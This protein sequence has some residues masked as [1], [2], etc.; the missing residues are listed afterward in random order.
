M[1]H[2]RPRP[3]VE[4]AVLLLR[5]L[6]PPAGRRA[7]R[8]PRLSAAREC[9]RP[10]SG[11]RLTG[12]EAARGYAAPRRIHDREDETFF[13]LDGTVRFVAGDE[14]HSAGPGVLALLPRR[15]PHAFVVTSPNARLLTLITPAGFEGFVVEAGTPPD[16]PVEGPPDV[17]A[18]KA[19]G[20][21]YGVEIIGP[22]PVP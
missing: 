21:R 12:G 16:A 2:P 9:L 15:M 14:E 1:P 10:T 8:G 18:L 11:P 19:M 17:E 4:R 7:T 13:V 5:A 3:P 20:T 6:R 22:P